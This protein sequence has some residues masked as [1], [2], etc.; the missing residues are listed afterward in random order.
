[1]P[2]N[3]SHPA[4][5]RHRA[6]TG[7]ATAVTAVISLALVHQVLITVANWRTYLLVHDYLAGKRAAA[8]LL[9]A[10]SDALAKLGSVWVSLVVWIAAGVTWLVWLWRA[11]INSEL[12]SGVAAHRR[13]RGWVAG[14]WMAPVANLWIPY[15][16]VSDVWRASAPR[17]P[18]SITLI[19]AW[20]ALFV[21]A[22]FV[23]K[24]LQWR[25]SQQ[26][27]SENDV[28]TNAYLSTMLTALYA[29]AGLLLV[30]IV[31]RITEWQSGRHAGNDA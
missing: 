7:S 3:P 9:A 10:E 13:S 15:Q 21:I 27:D 26:F 14:G 25:A 8:D 4:D 19:N 5:H 24:P 28:L 2:T 22:S 23:V 17:R 30:L 16:I 6:V 12:M 31:R 20:W 29:V 11:R 1:M 18:V